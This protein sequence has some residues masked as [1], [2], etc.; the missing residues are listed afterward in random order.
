MSLTGS[1]QPPLG[2][3]PLDWAMLAM[4]LAL[5]VMIAAI[6]TAGCVNPERAM[7][8]AWEGKVADIALDVYQE[9]D[10][11]DRLERDAAKAEKVREVMA[12]APG[13]LVENVEE[14]AVGGGALG[15]LGAGVAV[16]RKRRKERKNAESQTE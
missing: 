12:A 13:W 5:A 7:R 11:L 3:D 14:L 10:A 9:R 8:K 4:L 6:V 2:R 15:V 16:W 1:S